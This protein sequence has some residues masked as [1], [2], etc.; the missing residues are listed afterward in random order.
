MQEA[1]RTDLPGWLCLLVSWLSS[2]LYLAVW[3]SQSTTTLQSLQPTVWNMVR[4]WYSRKSLVFRG[5][6]IQWEISK[7][8]KSYSSQIWMPLWVLSLDSNSKNLGLSRALWQLTLAKNEGCGHNFSLQ[9]VFY[10]CRWPPL[11]T[12][13]PLSLIPSITHPQYST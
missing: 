11:L 6:Y 4:Y 10:S 9:W 1:V 2:A 12:L 8:Q 7:C 3:S 13:L 5:L